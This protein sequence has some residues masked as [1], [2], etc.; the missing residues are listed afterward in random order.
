MVLA[1]VLGIAAASFCL[2]LVLPPLRLADESF[3]D[4]L[5]GHFSP[6]EPQHPGIAMVAIGEDS[7]VAPACRSPVDRAF[8]AD[9]IGRLRAAKVRAIGIDIL[10][11]QPTLPQN[12]ERLR[13]R[14][15]D[16][17]VPVV[18]ISAA[19]TGV[20]AKD[21]GV[22][23]FF[24]KPFNL[25]DLVRRVRELVA[26]PPGARSDADPAARSVEMRECLDELANQMSA[27]YG[28]VE[29][30]SED[31]NVTLLV[32]KTA[33]NAVDASQRA[34]ALLRRI[35]HLVGAEEVPARGE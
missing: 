25:D 12:D 34:A 31:P 9:L 32:R 29:L 15:S 2:P 7:F 30:I 18:A 16:P 13:R 1:I 21:L 33:T 22:D 8:L 27:I 14:L 11:D 3:G 24:P 4:L 28:C 10:F 23:A 35:R 26:Q 17:G 19:Y 6:P 20:R 5:I